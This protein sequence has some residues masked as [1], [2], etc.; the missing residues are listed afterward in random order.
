M[1]VVHI[2]LQ[3]FSQFLQDNGASSNTIK[4]YIA[5][6]TVFFRYLSDKQQP[7]SFLTIDSLLSTSSL[8]NY[9]QYLLVSFPIATVKRR[10][11]SL[12]KFCEFV[13][14]SH[15]VTPSI[16]VSTIQ[17]PIPELPSP[18]PPILHSKGVS[19]PLFVI[20]IV[21]T[22]SVSI[23]GGYLASYSAHQ[24]AIG[25]VDPSATFI[26]GQTR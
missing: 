4:N 15:L 24:S 20:F 8:E 10:L 25:L 14:N 17:Y 11:S 6:I 21:L 1:N 19:S 5:D 9:H 7:I 22:V 26:N 16:P 23:I 2:L 3:N 13:K 12:N 18:L